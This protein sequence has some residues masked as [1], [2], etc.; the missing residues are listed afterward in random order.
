MWINI[1]AIMKLT[2]TI[3]NGPKSFNLF[4]YL[5]PKTRLKKRNNTMDTC[6]DMV[7]QGENSTWRRVLW[8]E[9]TSS[10]EVFRNLCIQY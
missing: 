4:E 6:M 9:S 5:C 1:A 2:R 3:I 7:R 8:L 10:N